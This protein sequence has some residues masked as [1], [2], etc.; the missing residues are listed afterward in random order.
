MS[1]NHRS[2]KVAFAVTEV[3]PEVASGDYFTAMELGSSLRKLLRW[4]VIWLPKEDWYN[5][6]DANILIAM[7]DHYELPRL[8]PKAA[9]LVKICWMRNWFD[10]W[11]SKPHFGMWDIRLCSS[12]KASEHIKDRYGFTSSVLRIATNQSRFRPRSEDKL[13]DYVFT[14]SYW[15]AP[16]DIEKIDPAAIGLRFALFGKN[17]ED[18]P[19][20]RAYFKGFAPYHA[21]PRIYNQ[22]RIL[23]DDANS[24]TKEWG[25]VNSR[26]FD[27]LASGTLVITNSATGSEEV[28]NNKLPVYNSP[29]ELSKILHLYSTNSEEY[30]ARL[31]YLRSHV[32]Q[33]H[34]YEIRAN[35]FNSIFAKHLQNNLNHNLKNKNDN[36]KININL[37][38][39]D[40]LVSI[41]IP[42][43]NQINF[44]IKCLKSIIKN[45]PNIYEIIIVDNGSTDNT[46]KILSEFGDKIRLLRNVTNLGFAKA[47]NIGA[48]SANTPFLL[49]LNND[50]EVLPG[51]LQP[52]LETIG[53]ENVGA[54][55]SKLLFPDGSIQ[56]AG[57][58]I[59]EQT[60]KTSLLPRHAFIRENPESTPPNEAK[61]F[62][63]VTAACMLVEKRIFHDAGGFD[64]SYWNGCEDVDLCFKL[65]QLGKKII[66][67]PRSTVIHY[68]GKSGHERTIAINSNNARLRSKWEGIIN[69]DIIDN[70]DEIYWNNNC[71]S[72]NNTEEYSLNTEYKN[73]AI[74][75]WAKY[76]KSY[77]PRISSVQNK[78]IALRICTPS[79]KSVGWGDTYFGEQLAE[80]FRKSGNSCDVYVKNEWY[81]NTNHDIAIHIKGIYRYYPNKACKNILWIISHPELISKEELDSYDIILC[82]S[83]FFKKQI[84]QI[85]TKPCHF[86]PQA[87]TLSF[88][89]DTQQQTDEIDI[90]FVGNNYE[91][92][93]NRRRQI[94]Q[95]IIDARIRYEI[96]IIGR[97]WDGYISNNMLLAE[98]IDQESIPKY[99]KMAKINLNDHQYTM[100][101][102]GFINNRTYDLAALKQF[103]I[104]NHTH[105]LN[106]LG[107]TTY[108][109]TIDLKH[110]I[111]YYISNANARNEIA[112][113]SHQKCI[114]ETFDK[115]AIDI[116][117]L[118]N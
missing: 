37:N 14:G 9:G 54:V 97:F 30:N 57:V 92:K 50:T 11:A 17:W 68:E 73:S 8:G 38:K 28:F 87:T 35:E 42:V 110:K 81:E 6:G 111:E 13:Y 79:K 65:R 49:F 76:R 98:N 1:N 7:T 10:R 19:Q 108:S 75:W 86:F 95:D 80:S 64:E 93:N 74:H 53:K 41:I 59:I 12:L 102:Y 55:G 67:D 63:A 58:V 104:S 101:N 72:T 22:S 85:T 106:E 61:R 34:T 103:Q 20:F 31:R 83:Y 118:I 113:Y 16:R 117:K 91:Y 44:T 25:S 70:N 27:S 84:E 77:L 51:W 24:V 115:R 60:G 47:C 56:H 78:K 40:K 82:A 52:L 23:V 66:Y 32:L 109:N 21:M 69:P 46:F 48:Y 96:K 33:N 45:T 26:V 29:E 36:Y 105:G 4:E 3:G 107:V 71:N 116:L 62:Q 43:F 39:K 112:Q 2:F 89:N 90:L 88:I 100:A 99:Y 18:H 94:I 5:V 15:G 114:N